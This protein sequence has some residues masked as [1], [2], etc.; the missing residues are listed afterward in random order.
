VATCVRELLKS[1]GQIEIGLQIL[2]FDRHRIAAG[3]ARD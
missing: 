1:L 2:G 3:S